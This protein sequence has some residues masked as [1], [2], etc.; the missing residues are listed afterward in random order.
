MDWSVF[1]IHAAVLIV[2]FTA[3]IFGIAV[4]DI[5]AFVH[6]C[7]PE[8]REEYYRVNGRPDG[9]EDEGKGPA[10]ANI[11]DLIAIPIFSAMIAVFARF[12][13]ASTFWDGFLYT[14]AVFGVVGAWDTFVIDWILVANLPLFRLPGTEHM[15]AAYHQKWFHLKGMLFPGLMYAAIMGMLVGIICMMLG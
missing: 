12:C 15:D 4:I 8:I 6:D 11:A 10:Q 7:P 3:F 9:D 13:G 5:R 1:F 2:L 14:I